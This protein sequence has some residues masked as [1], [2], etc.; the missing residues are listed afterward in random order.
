MKEKTLKNYISFRGSRAAYSVVSCAI[1]WKFKYIQC[2]MYILVTNKNE[3]HQIKNVG[4]RVIITLYICILDAQGQLTPYSEVGNGQNS[5]PFKLLCTSLFPARM[6]KIHPKMKAL[7]WTQHFSNCKIFTDAQRQLNL[8][9]KIWSA[10]N[11]NSF[12]F[13]WVS[14]LPAKMKKI[15]SKKKALEWSTLYIYF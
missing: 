8:Q 7:E 5:N 2:F 14:L 13:V 6:K 10:W 11:L 9:S 1:W 4:A 15:Q 3:E 12:R